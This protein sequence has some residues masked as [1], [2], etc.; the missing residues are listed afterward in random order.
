MG[1]ASSLSGKASGWHVVGL[2]T[3]WSPEC[4][5]ESKALQCHT[6][7]GLIVVPGDTQNERVHDTLSGGG[8]SVSSISVHSD[9]HCAKSERSCWHQGNRAKTSRA[10]KVANKCRKLEGPDRRGRENEEGSAWCGWGRRGSTNEAVLS[11]FA[12]CH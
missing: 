8:G 5:E 10:G 11:S 12:E 1:L 3:R 4:Q 2:L 6:G 7:S 9:T